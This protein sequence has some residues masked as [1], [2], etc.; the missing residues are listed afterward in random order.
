MELYVFLFE[1]INKY[2][3]NRKT[4]QVRFIEYIILYVQQD[5]NLLNKYIIHKPWQQTFKQYFVVY[6]YLFQLIDICKL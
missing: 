2:S 5:Y 6:S 3:N 1:I 4:L